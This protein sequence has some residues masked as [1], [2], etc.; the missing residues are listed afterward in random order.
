M[1]ANSTSGSSRPVTFLPP[2]VDEPRCGEEVLAVE[3][4][5]LGHRI[6]PAGVGHETL[7]SA[8]FSCSPVQ[9][10]IPAEAAGLI[11]ALRKDRAGQGVD[12]GPGTIAWYLG[13]HHQARCPEQLSARIWPARSDYDLTDPARA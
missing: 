2:P 3:V 9:A 5:H 6:V 13:R 4:R 12:T 1:Q 8:I 10:T 7:D 11:I